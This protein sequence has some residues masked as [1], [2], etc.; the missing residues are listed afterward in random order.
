M[1]TM[2]VA[3]MM[4]VLVMMI[5][6]MVVLVLII[7]VVA[8]VVVVVVVLVVVVMKMWHDQCL[9]YAEHCGCLQKLVIIQSGKSRFIAFSRRCPGSHPRRAEPS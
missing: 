6:M 2:V 1:I 9:K 4:M 7:V 8:L 3:L 5:M